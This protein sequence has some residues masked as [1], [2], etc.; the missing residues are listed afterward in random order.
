MTDDMRQS[1]RRPSQKKSTAWHE[2]WCFP[3]PVAPPLS[4]YV[5]LIFLRCYARCW[6][7]HRLCHWPPL[8]PQPRQSKQQR[9][10]NP[11]GIIPCLR[12]KPVRVFPTA[13]LERCGQNTRGGSIIAL[14]FLLVC[15]YLSYFLGC[16]SAMDTFLVLFGCE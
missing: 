12:P 1:S 3:P 10:H 13:T 16:T 9:R 14:L 8:P 7:E 15:L 11:R 5:P 2:E 6:M 4:P